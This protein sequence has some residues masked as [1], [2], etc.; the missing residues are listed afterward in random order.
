MR[1]RRRAGT[2]AR[3]TQTRRRYRGRS[4]PS[5][6]HGGAVG[7][8]LWCRAWCGSAGVKC[9]AL[10]ALQASLWGGLPQRQ[11]MGGH[12]AACTCAFGGPRVFWTWLPNSL[13][14]WHRAVSHGRQPV[15]DEWG[16]RLSIE[17]TRAAPSRAGR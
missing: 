1:S 2:R 5:S 11:T 17:T 13:K 4:L 14:S 7:R 6:E 3:R 12:A 15:Y 16:E 9:S 10:P 8:R